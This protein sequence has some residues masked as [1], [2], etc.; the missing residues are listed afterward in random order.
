M[1]K[2]LKICGWGALAIALLFTLILAVGSPVAKYI[3]NN[4]GEDI[5]GRQMHVDQVVINPFWGG[6]SI[7]GFE[8]KEK[9]GV[10]N[11]V[12][13]DRLYVQVAYPQLVA[14]HL[15][16]RAIHLAGFNGQVL[17][18]S[19]GLNLTDIIERFSKDSTE[20]PQDTTPSKWTVAL[21]DIRLDN[22]AIR[23]RDVEG[24]KQ[25][26]LEDIS[27]H[28]PGLYFDNTQT[29]AGLEFAL[30]TGGRVGI[31]AGYKMLANRYAVRVTLDDVHTNVALPLIQD[32]LNVSG[33]GAV[34]NGQIHV[35]GS[36]ENAT[37][38]QVQGAISM[39]GLT[40]MQGHI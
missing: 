28:I 26:K 31:V 19:A 24:R 2:F 5:I 20:Q 7:N 18:D 38:L 4:K 40:I 25:W 34:L 11:F 32:Y 14:K 21:D 1:K 3:V 8:C 33:L 9:N 15:K 30:P 12:S 37:N 22:S 36:L 27:L 29:N 39:T 13:F 10:S 6:V 35:D 17:K 23:Y 16:V